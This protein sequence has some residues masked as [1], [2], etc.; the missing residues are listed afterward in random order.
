LKETRRLQIQQKSFTRSDLQKIGKLFL[1]EADTAAAAKK[2]RAVAF[3]L[4]CSDQTSYTTEDMSQFAEGAEIDMKSTEAVQFTFAIEDE[5]FIDFNLRSGQRSDGEVMV[6]GTD[7]KW[8]GGM[9]VA[10]EERIRAVNP[11]SSWFTKHP[12]LTFN[13][14]AVG[15][16]SIIAWIV[17]WGH[18]LGLVTVEKSTPAMEQLVNNPVV[19]FIGIWVAFWIF[20]LLPAISARDWLL[21]AWPSIE[22]DTGPEHQKIQKIR[23]NRIAAF[24]TLVVIPLLVTSVYDL[25]KKLH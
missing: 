19:N 15:L 14:V 16:G 24:I 9:F 13:I 2:R 8:V 10:L 5:N 23:R 25:I 11:S 7:R 22:L 1:V 17:V 6:R 20:G 12:T 4:H 18:H 21:A 3:T